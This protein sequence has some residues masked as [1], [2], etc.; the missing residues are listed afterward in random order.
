MVWGLSDSDLKTV[1]AKGSS[2]VWCP[3]S[4]LK[5]LGKTLSAERLHAHQRLLLGTDSRL[6]GS[7]DMLMELKVATKHMYA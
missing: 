5:L 3:A 2:I 6:S 7:Q 4:N 1:L